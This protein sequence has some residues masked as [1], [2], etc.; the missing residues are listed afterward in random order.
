MRLIPFLLAGAAILS[1]SAQAA[2]LSDA[3]AKVYQTNPSLTGARA[4]LRAIDEGVPL[5]KALARPGVSATVGINQNY[6]DIPTSF[7]DAGRSLTANASVTYPIFQGGR[8]DNTIG[9]AESRVEAGRANL[10]ATEA[11]TFTDAV[12]A[13]LN[14]IRDE[15]IVRLNAGSVQVL[16]A[17]LQ[18]SRDRFEVGDVT[19]TDVAQSEARL[20]LARSQLD[21]AQAQLTVSREDYHRIIG[22]APEALEP[23][24]PLPPLPGTPA[25]AV[26]IAAA[27]NPDVQAARAQQEAARFDVGTARAERLP[28]VSVTSGANYTNYLGTLDNVVGIG[29]RVANVQTTSRV[30][31]TAQMPLYQGGAPAARIRQA[32]ARESQAIE[33]TILIERSVVA[34]ARSAYANW[35]AARAVI[36]SSE[37]AVDANRLALEGTRAENS[38]GT[39]N[40]LD[41]LNAEQELLNSQVQ[42]IS[43]RRN[44]YVAGFVL[45]A[46]MG[47][48]EAENLGLDGGA[49]YDPVANYER[50]RNRASDWRTDP[51]P[52][53]QATRTIGPPE[54]VTPAQN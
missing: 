49:L 37:V 14:V 3:L 7:V 31:V 8:V 39:R 17:N 25:Q 29:A 10:R 53:P 38:V 33:Q 40:V 54:G 46:A 34:Q 18:A 21:S 9:A 24:P 30:G 2:T 11:T 32:Q 16:E 45:L 20:A 4:S 1:G 22:E 5:A 51:A 26:D 48:A 41:V 43:A 47:R 19:R 36:Q 28:T 23:P 13:Y 15:G 44:E 6:R 12:A 27:N 42:L 50:V 35:Q 52:T